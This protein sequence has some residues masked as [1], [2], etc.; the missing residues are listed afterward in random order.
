[1]L[2]EFPRIVFSGSLVSEKIALLG[3]ALLGDS[4]TSANALPHTQTEPTLA[5]FQ[6]CPRLLKGFRYVLP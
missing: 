2:F 6:K 5:L 3:I 1:M 4:E